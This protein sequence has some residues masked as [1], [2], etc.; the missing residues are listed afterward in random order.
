MSF[1]FD[2]SVEVEVGGFEELRRLLDDIVALDV[3]LADVQQAYGG[4][5]DAVDGGDQRASHDRE[6]DELLGGAVDVG[7][8]VERRGHA[9]ARR[10]L[11]RDGGPVDA[12]QGLEHEARNRHQGAGV[13]GRDA[14]LRRPVLDEID[15]DAHRRIL[16]AAQRACGAFAHFDHFGRSVHGDSVERGR[17]DSV[18]HLSDVGF[19]S[20][21][22]D[23]RVRCLLQKSD[24]CMNGDGRPVVAA[25][26]VHGYANA[27]R[28]ECDAMLPSTAHPWMD[29]DS[30]LREFHCGA[31]D[32]SRSGA[33]QGRAP[34]TMRVDY[35][36]A[37]VL[38][39]FL[40]R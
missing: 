39:I 16:L 13:A 17:T 36:S 38:T 1:A 37:L 2:V 15:G 8:Q 31:R 7:A 5:L 34:G 20:D 23:A 33:S 24:R 32:G 10:Q 40:P 6:L 22:D 19:A 28:F 35:S 30:S 9:F 4:T 27:H 14:S 18:E 29:N 12:G 21:Q 3:F 11:R 25:H 26:R